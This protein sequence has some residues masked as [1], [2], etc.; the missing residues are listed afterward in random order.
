MAIRLVNGAEFLHIPK[1]GGSWVESVLAANQLIQSKSLNRHDDYD[2]NLHQS[3]GGVTGDRLVQFYDKARRRLS[4]TFGEYWGRANKTPI[5]RFCFVRHPLRWYES[6]WKYMQSRD[7]NRWGTS[8][9]AYEWHPNSVLNG[10][11]S[12]DF[13]TFVRNVVQ[14]RPGY[15][16]ELLYSFTKLGISYIGKTETLRDDLCQVFKVLELKF[17]PAT[18]YESAKINASEEIDSEIHWDAGLRNLV[19]R[20]ELPSLIYFDYLSN[21]EKIELGLDNLPP[22]PALKVPFTARTE[23]VSSFTADLNNTS[24]G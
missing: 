12:G 14:K 23:L 17:D 7:W 18:I 5:F 24:I 10:L 6:W 2:R 8:N 16:T 11:G 9:S 4:R 13:N 15:V 1:T 20:L 3:C 22:H 19:L 21:A